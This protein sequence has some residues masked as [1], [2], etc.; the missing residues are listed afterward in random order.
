MPRDLHRLLHDTAV[1]P[2]SEPNVDRLV[3]RGRRRRRRRYTAAGLGAATVLVGGVVIGANGLAGPTPPEIVD[4]P[5]VASESPS[6]IPSPSADP[7]TSPSASPEPVR[8]TGPSQSAE[9]ASRDGVLPEVAALTFDQRVGLPEPV[10]EHFS[11]RA[12]TDEGIWVVSRMPAEAAPAADGCGLGATND[13]NA[14][15]RRDVICTVEYGEVLLLNHAEDEILRAFPLPGVPPQ[16][17]AVSEGAVWCGGAGDGGLPDG[18]LCRIDRQTFDWQAR[19]FPHNA[20]TSFTDA[21][22][23]GSGVDPDT[24]KLWLPDNWAVDDGVVSYDQAFLAG[25]WSFED[26]TLVASAQGALRFDPATL[27]PVPP[28]DVSVTTE[29]APD[30]NVVTLTTTVTLAS[31]E[32][33]GFDPHVAH[34]LHGADG[35]PLPTEGLAGHLTQHIIEPGRPLQLY[36]EWTNWC[37]EQEPA[38]VV[39]AAGPFG[40]WSSPLTVVP[41]CQD[42]DSP[43]RLVGDTR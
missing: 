13:P 3:Q 33:C 12:E 41:P 26:A 39:F 9:E 21:G 20:Q 23:A 22:D 14:V 5:P 34:E 29:A 24:G 10:Q 43:S 15:Y 16:R 2:H 17:L 32:S 38:E 31:G 40:R 8:P 27:A 28:C 11:V 37:G 25:R 4:Q 6:A 30:G 36:A 7:T 19:V 42:A 18:V 1:E 35:W